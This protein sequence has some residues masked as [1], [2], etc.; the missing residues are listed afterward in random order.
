M[1]NW[2]RRT[3]IVFLAL[4]VS[5]LV[6]PA[7]LAK[8]KPPEVGKPDATGANCKPRVMVILKGSVTDVTSIGTTGAGT[9]TM[10]ATRTNRHGSAVGTGTG[11]VVK[12][13]DSTTFRRNGKAAR[14]DLKVDD[15]VLVQ[16]RVCKADT[17][18]STT[19]LNTVAKRVI[20]HPAQPAEAQDNS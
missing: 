3:R 19:I 13:D 12:I 6:V 17:S 9:F 4:A 8:G 5:I 7:A 15:R 20:A 11:K 1:S 18:G 2:T 14:G 16:I 10:E